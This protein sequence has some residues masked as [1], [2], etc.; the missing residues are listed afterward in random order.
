MPTIGRAGEDLR[1]WTLECRDAAL[2]GG[3][4]VVAAFDDEEI[5]LSRSGIRVE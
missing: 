1:V 2:G 3:L 4:R 5:D